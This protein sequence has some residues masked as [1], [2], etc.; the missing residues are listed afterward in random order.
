MQVSQRALP[1]SKL[2]YVIVSGLRRPNTTD[3]WVGGRTPVRVSTKHGLPVVS[4]W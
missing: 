1:G 2:D 3:P 4:A